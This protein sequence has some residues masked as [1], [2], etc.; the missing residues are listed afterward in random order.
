MK[1]PKVLFPFLFITSWIGDLVLIFLAC[2]LAFTHQGPLS[3]VLF[4]TIAFCI[5]AGSL[6]PIGTYLLYLR[7]NRMLLEAEAAE[8]DIRVREALRRAEAVTDR[9]DEAEGSLAKGILLARQVPE[10][11]EGKFRELESVAGRLEALPLERLVESG[12]QADRISEDLAG[13]IRG[14]ETGLRELDQFCRF[15]PEKIHETES[16]GPTHPDSES[17]VP[18]EE[19]LDLL[20]E[21]V[22]ANQE[23][24]D[25]LMVRILSEVQAT[26]TASANAPSSIETREVQEPM[27]STPVHDSDPQAEMVLEPGP[28]DP[29]PAAD[30]SGQTRVVAHAMVGMRNALYLRGDG[31]LLSWDR[32]IRMDLI[33]IGEFAW[34]SDDLREPIEVA[35]LLNDDLEAEGGPVT[36]KPG[37]ILQISPV[38]PKLAE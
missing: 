23:S 10:R 20:H 2:F 12:S 18:L 5:L 22:E 31:P 36:L 33:G 26:A 19:R 17:G 28:P 9:L 7:W 30:A 25:G 4:L 13:R 29:P 34:S 24:L 32:G 11:I 27:D 37:E 16:D 21:S 35:L 15:L 8:A 14:L 6:L 3:P 38:F 1:D